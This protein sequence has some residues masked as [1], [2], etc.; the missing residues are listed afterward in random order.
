MTM[1]LS[2][3]SELKPI[4]DAMLAEAEARQ[5][6]YDEERKRQLRH[7]PKRERCYRCK[8]AGVLS[9]QGADVCCP[10]C[11]GQG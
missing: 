2:S 11:G 5:K 4:R 10:S 3:F 7:E 6:K 1:K 8:G 9:G